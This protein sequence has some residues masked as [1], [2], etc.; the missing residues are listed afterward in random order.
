MPEALDA[1]RSGKVPRKAGLLLD[2][3]NLQYSLNVGGEGFS[4]GSLKLPEVEDAEN[5]RV[6]FEERIAL[7]RDFCKTF[8]ALFASFLKTRA[9]SGW[10]GQSGS[11][12]KWIQHSSRNSAIAAVA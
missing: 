6:L 12:R 5:P 10:E 9:S 4:F 3:N 7:L 1:L 11:I 8:D 2:A